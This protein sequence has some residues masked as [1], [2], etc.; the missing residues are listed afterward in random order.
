MARPVVTFSSILEAENS[1]L[2]RTIDQVEFRVDQRTSLVDAAQVKDITRA[3]VQGFELVNPEL[4]DCKCRTKTKLEEA[5]ERMLE[6]SKV[7][8]NAELVILE[9]HITSLKRSINTPE[10]STHTWAR[11]RMK[12][13]KASGKC[14]TCNPSLD[15]FLDMSMLLSRSYHSGIRLSMQ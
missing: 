8:C 5:F 2:G 15:H 11:H 7:Q 12:G 13:T 6:A 10:D 4:L 1:R 3:G 9:D 14:C